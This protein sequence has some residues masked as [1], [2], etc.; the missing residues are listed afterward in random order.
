MPRVVKQV[1][2]QTVGTANT[3]NT[4]VNLS[5]EG[6]PFNDYIT[7]NDLPIVEGETNT[8]TTIYYYLGVAAP[9]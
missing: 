5:L 7:S 9:V 6:I 1:I 2:V 3:H 8:Y 4:A